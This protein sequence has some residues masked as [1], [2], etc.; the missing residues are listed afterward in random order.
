[1][2]QIKLAEHVNRFTGEPCKAAGS[3]GV[4]LEHSIVDPETGQM[5]VEIRLW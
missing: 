1:M 3:L 5:T 4:A 2:Q